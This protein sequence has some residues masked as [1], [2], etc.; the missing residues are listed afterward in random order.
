MITA[1]SMNILQLCHVHFVLC[2]DYV[3]RECSLSPCW[4]MGSFFIGVMGTLMLNHLINFCSLICKVF[5]MNGMAYFRTCQVL[6][7]LT[8]VLFLSLGSVRFTCKFSP[9]H[10]KW[11]LNPALFF[12]C[13]ILRRRVPCRRVKY[14]NWGCVFFGSSVHRS[15]SNWAFCEVKVILFP[16]CAL[17]KQKHEYCRNWAVVLSRIPRPHPCA[18]LHEPDVET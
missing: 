4:W 8:L 16:I 7:F 11:V 10:H 17:Q 3:T 13:I 6:S 18:Y 14:L 9:M 12:M 2:Y 1:K 5:C 15:L